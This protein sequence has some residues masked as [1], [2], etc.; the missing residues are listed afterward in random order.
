MGQ[1]CYLQFEQ[2]TRSIFDEKKSRHTI[3]TI[4]PVCISIF[5]QLLIINTLSVINEYYAFKI[6]YR[7]N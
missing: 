3:I 1:I 4:K 6:M 7:V 5:C 2:E